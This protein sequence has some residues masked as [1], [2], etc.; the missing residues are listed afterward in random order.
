M[1][2][3]TDED[4][5]S[6][7]EGFDP[8]NN[9]WVTVSKK[10][11]KKMYRNMNSKNENESKENNAA[12]FCG[13][14]EV[15]M[16]TKDR[17]LECGVCLLKYHVSCQGVSGKLYEALTDDMDSCAWF[18]RACKE[19]A[20]QLRLQIIAIQRDQLSI[21]TDLD[22]LTSASDRNSAG[23]TMLK[24]D[25][26]KIDKK[27]EKYHEQLQTK[28]NGIEVNRT[29]SLQVSDKIAALQSKLERRLDELEKGCGSFSETCG[30]ASYAQAAAS[31]TAL[32]N[33]I[34]EL[35]VAVKSAQARNAT[36]DTRALKRGLSELEDIE[37][38]KLN[39]M[40]F[41]LPEAGSDDGDIKTFKNMIKSEFKLSVQVQE[42]TRLGKVND[43]G[44]R[45]LRVKLEA[46]SEKK[47]IL[48]RAK[49]LRTSRHEIFAQVFIRPD[50]TKCQLE[51][52]KNLRALLLEKRQ[53]F[54]HKEWTIRRNEVIMVTSNTL[55][56]QS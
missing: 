9:E 2:C 11:R 23:M 4:S 28:I 25:I 41:N 18:C 50:L 8:K 33:K 31:V 43:A 16:D 36:S 21:K 56:Q 39:L 35:S 5:D 17:S 37:S 42:A 26:S 7:V 19:G 30:P 34:D 51:A 52:S 14:C 54:P 49:D 12:S 46:M 13:S 15:K 40:V 44:P 24:A 1:H 45:M 48:A 10:K 32:E 55:S 29:G 38:R 47:L 27:L 6:H 20:K 22:K 53:A 3:S